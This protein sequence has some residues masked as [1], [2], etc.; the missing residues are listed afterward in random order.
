MAK[1][2]TPPQ[3]DPWCKSVRLPNGQLISGASAREYRIKAKG[4]IPA[5]VKEATDRVL[6]AY[7]EQQTSLT[8]PAPTPTPTRPSKRPTAT[9]SPASGVVH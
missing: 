5:I 6:A 9:K 2:D 4:G 7:H 8:P 1:R 3:K